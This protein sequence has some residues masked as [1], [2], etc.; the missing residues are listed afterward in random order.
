MSD[1][2]PLSRERLLALEPENP[3]LR[4]EYERRLNAM[5]ET[6][7]TGY[8]KWAWRVAP[9]FFLGACASFAMRAWH[10]GG[11]PPVGRAGFAVGALFAAAAAVQALRVAVRG[12]L[13]RPTDVRAA[14]QIQLLFMVFGATI[15]LY[16]TPQMGD[17][18]H[19]LQ[20]LG[21]VVVFLVGGV[22]FLVQHLIEQSELNTRVRLLELEY[23]LARLTESVGKSAT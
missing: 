3:A 20:A 9:V 22:A 21:I 12:T 8:R 5:L 7:L 16:A 17:L 11:L 1:K 6:Q 19:M 2:T 4:A 10:P 18:P 23:Q 14:T 15:F 13:R